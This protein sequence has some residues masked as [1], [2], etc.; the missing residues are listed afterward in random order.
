MKR[1]NLLTLL[2]WLLG[3][4]GLLAQTASEAYRLAANDLLGTARNLGTGNSMFAIGP[5]L[6]AITQN[7]SGL[8]GYRKSE[9]SLTTGL[10]FQRY[11]TGLRNGPHSV[12]NQS[13]FS[14]PNLGVVTVT[15]PHG[16]WTT[17]NFAIGMNRTGEYRRQIRYQGYAVGS[18]TD[19][20]RELATG[21]TPDELNG[22]EEGLAYSSG[23]IYD[24]ESDNL[25]ESDYQLSPDYRLYRQENTFLSGGQSE[26]YLA[27][28]TNYRDV[29][30][31][32]ASVSVPIV[33]F[34]EEREYRE[35]DEPSNAVP[36]FNDLTYTRSIN[37]TGYG[38]QGKLGVTV[39]PAP[40]LSLAFAAHTATKLRMTD[41]YN[42]TVTYDFTDDQHDGPIV[43]ESPYGSFEY[44]L[45]LPWRLMGGIGVVAGQR[46]FLSASVSWTD[47][48]TMRY[49]YSVRGN[50][51][52]Y[53]QAERAVNA[54]IRNT[55]T[56]AFAVNMGGE[57]AIQ[58]LRLRAGLG[59]E[60]SA[61]LNDRS[62]STAYHGGIGYRWDGFFLDAGYRYDTREEGF[63]PY[64]TIDAP[65]PVVVSTVARHR[66]AVTFGVKF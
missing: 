61:Y 7:P 42:T 60:Q 24:F 59:L 4:A 35:M 34:N 26:I 65:Q 58:G 11:D 6:S 32:G 19:A 63:L 49:D 14:L 45:R 22:F 1:K 9:F 13:R 17:A 62:F 16:D 18:I 44:A 53:E 50:G 55:Y 21:K 28:A 2:A 36:F 57:L 27:Y 25:Y 43:S 5:D 39:K 33:N 30:Q 54:D 8:A 64:E 3:T 37:S 46:G 66:F 48:G 51:N 29:L 15:R 52:F 41:N 12:S 10:H 23:A 38:F 47:Y 40:A 56:T 31:I 20:W